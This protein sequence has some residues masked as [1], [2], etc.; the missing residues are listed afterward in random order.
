MPKPI[1]LEDAHAVL[2]SGF[3]QD[4][5][6]IG[7]L[8][9]R[10]H[11]TEAQYQEALATAEI[12]VVSG[13]SQITD[14][15]M[16]SMPKLKLI[17]VFGVGYD[18]IDVKAAKA[19]GIKVTHTPGVMKDDVADM[20][21]ALLLNCTRELVEAHKFIERGDWL[22]GSRP[23]TVPLNHMKVGIAGL[24][25][26]GIEIA[27][28]L[29]AFRCEIAYCATHK[30][31]NPY[32]YFDN[33]KDLATWAQ[34]LIIIMPLNAHTYHLVDA[35]V[36]KALGPDGYL[37]NVAR[38]KIVDTEALI[39][40]LEKHEIRGCGLDVLEKEPQLPPS[41]LLNKPNVVLAPHL[42]SATLGTRNAMAK[43][44]LDNI[45]TYLKTGAV[46]SMVPELS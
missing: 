33:I 27:R 4:L 3:M 39:K 23:L 15:Y 41:E 7:T 26:I 24:G 22:K 1:I 28:R 37:V 13:G 34:A 36:L 25:R 35:E 14:A 43:L 11:A 44:V 31:D 46:I 5:G 2:Q 17:T 10:R 29:E 32:I 42:G 45:N 9:S 6:T 12:L 19:R 20:A 30:H 8:I 21:M 38:G 16:D 18:G 40:A